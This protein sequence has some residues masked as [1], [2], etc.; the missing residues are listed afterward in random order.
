MILTAFLLSQAVHWRLEL[1][2]H[3]YIDWTRDPLILFDGNLILGG[4]ISYPSW[5]NIQGFCAMVDTAT[6]TIIWD[7]KFTEA[8]W[9]TITHLAGQGNCFYAVGCG[10]KEGL[11]ETK[12]IILAKMTG[13]GD[14]IWLKYD[15]DSVDSIKVTPMAIM[16]EP[17]GN[18]VSGGIGG[19]L[20]NITGL[21]LRSWDT[22]GNTRWDL[23]Y[24]PPPPWK[25]PCV[26]YCLR[27]DDE[28]S[29]Y[30]VG[31]CPIS[32]MM[33]QGDTFIHTRRFRG[34]GYPL[35]I[36]VDSSGR[37]VWVDTYRWW[38]KPGE[39]T[40][41]EWW[42]GGLFVT[43]MNSCGDLYTE[44]MDKYGVS[45]W[46]DWTSDYGFFINLDASCV[47]SGGNFYVTG[48][49]W[50]N[51]TLWIF[52]SSYTP[53]G[54]KRLLF[55]P[56]PGTGRCLAS[57]NLGN[58]FL[59]GTIIDTLGSEFVVV[60]MDTLGNFKWLYRK[61]TESPYYG[62]YGDACYSLLP[63]NRGG[64]FAMGIIYRADTT[65]VQYLVHLADTSS[66]VPESAQARP[67]LTIIPAP[68]G[69][70]ITCPSGEAR[71]YDSAGR[72]VMAREIKGKT[73]ISPLVPGVY[74]VVAGKERVKVAV[75]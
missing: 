47:D 61:D 11:P 24:Y 18:I 10:G 31:V 19:S 49:A 74:F 44:R 34:C 33:P 6:G 51:D 50:G 68:S 27:M 21:F 20:S 38:S 65:P 2:Y 72:L 29:I 45:L 59:G 13:S 53:Y 69:F 1:P 28:G 48:E 35:V 17:N 25:T 39:M 7:R 22:L 58:L 3:W 40:V 66:E 26:P 73:L 15:P 57:D 71:I 70:Y 14:V 5:G 67:D 75:R 43:G 32:G 60:K 12:S 62:I 41:C 42:N 16:I 52:V 54:L 46:F 4:H 55:T 63:D 9:S 30:G 64:V 56:F 37:L 36:K 8:E 23:F